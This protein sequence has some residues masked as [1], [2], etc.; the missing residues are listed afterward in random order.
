MLRTHKN[1]GVQLQERQTRQE[2]LQVARNDL[3]RR[4]LKLTSTP[5][6]PRRPRSG[7][8]NDTIR[9]HRQPISSKDAL[10]PHRYSQ[11]RLPRLR[12]LRRPARPFQ[13]G[14]IGRERSERTQQHPYL[15]TQ[16][17]EECAPDLLVLSSDLS[18]LLPQ[19]SPYLFLAPE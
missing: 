1:R 4:N 14:T 11:R 19:F 9:T 18:E 2:A 13:Q 6:L 8:G 17:G 16:G 5:L 7:N 12:V 15:P 10:P 3:Q